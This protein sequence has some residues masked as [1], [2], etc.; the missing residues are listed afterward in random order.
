MATKMTLRLPDQVAKDLKA[1]SASEG[2]SFNETAVRALQRGLGNTPDEE[3]WRAFGD[4]VAVPPTRKGFD[5][6]AMRDRRKAA[7]IRFT[8][9]DAEGMMQALDELRENRF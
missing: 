7:G 6:A 5:L 4:L 9:A 3:W 2:R 8:T 1:L